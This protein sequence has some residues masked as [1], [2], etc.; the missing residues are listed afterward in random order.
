MIGRRNYRATR[1]LRREGN[2]FSEH[3]LRDEVTGFPVRQGDAAEDAYGNLVDA[4]Y[5][6]AFDNPDTFP[7]ALREP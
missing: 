2:A 6:R 7:D 4:R 3:P 1:R 5:P